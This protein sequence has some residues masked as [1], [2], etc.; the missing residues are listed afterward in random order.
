MK[1]LRTKGETTAASLLYFADHGEDCYD[2]RL[3]KLLGHG[4]IANVPMTSVPLQVWLSPKLKALRPE[5]V[6]RASKP[7]ASYRLEQIIHLMIDLAS[8][9]NPDFSPADSLFPEEAK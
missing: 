2:S 6:A 8:L 7:K 4:Q 1:A 9:S 3:T 5:L